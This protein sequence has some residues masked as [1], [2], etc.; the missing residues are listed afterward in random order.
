MGKKKQKREY[1]DIS[2][3]HWQATT[4]KP[5]GKEIASNR[6]LMLI[7]KM[8]N[9]SFTGRKEKNIIMY[10]RTLVVTDLVDPKPSD[11]IKQQVD[12]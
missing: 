10:L 5:E 1:E 3:D 2:D 6:T 11:K 7:S 9:R 8:E 4:P 12:Q